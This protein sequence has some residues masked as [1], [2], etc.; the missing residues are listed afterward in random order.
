MKVTKRSCDVTPRSKYQRSKGH[1]WSP[2]ASNLVQFRLLFTKLRHFDENKKTGPRCHPQVVSSAGHVIRRSS[3]DCVIR[4]S[5]QVMSKSSLNHLKS[6]TKSRANVCTTMYRVYK[7]NQSSLLGLSS[8][9]VVVNHTALSG[10][11]P[12]CQPRLVI[13]CGKVYCG[14]VTM[15][16]N[17]NLVLTCLNTSV[18]R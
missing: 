5:C 9:G 14:T 12:Q 11:H 13:A 15:S 6:I 17:T 4:R 3:T 18:I 10:C 2:C 1:P 16:T 7:S 8:P